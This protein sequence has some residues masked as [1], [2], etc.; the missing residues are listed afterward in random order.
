MTPRKP[1]AWRVP[2]CVDRVA[3]FYWAS[4][5]SVYTA[6]LF[7]GHQDVLIMLLAWLPPDSLHR[8]LII[9]T[10]EGTFSCQYHNGCGQ[11]LLPS[12]ISST[13]ALPRRLALREGGRRRR[14]SLRGP[15]CVL[16]LHLSLVPWCHDLVL[17]L[18]VTHTV[19][20]V[21]PGGLTLLPAACLLWG[22]LALPRVC[23]QVSPLCARL[24]SSP[25]RADA[26]FL[27][28]CFRISVCYF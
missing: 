9:R 2:D 7:Q 4:L 19:C 18:G 13:C 8:R 24:R 28:P 12:A 14:Q 27:S 16:A 23:A 15:A 21:R 26:L 17:C 1:G 22:C 5:L 6:G 20:W 11:E 3:S 10:W 25:G